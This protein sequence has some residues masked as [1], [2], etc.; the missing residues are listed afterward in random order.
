MA[1]A[2][3]V[4]DMQV[5]LLDEGPWQENPLLEHV[6]I[7]IRRAPS[8][9][10]PVIFICDTRVEP[11]SQITSSLE[12]K[13]GDVVIHK[14]FCDSFLGTPLHARLQEASLG[15]L[16]V[17]GMQ[18]DCRIDTTCRRAASLGYQVQLASDAHSTLDQE[19]LSAAEIVA[20]HNRILLNFPAGSGH[21][22][23]VPAVEASFA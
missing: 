18:T 23:V 21:I 12:R 17:Y 11:D 1:T 13:P 16:I 5:G 6:S 14:D 20:H 4:I 15:N 2:L 8:A 19:H 7:L 9:S 10:S 3:L 22:D